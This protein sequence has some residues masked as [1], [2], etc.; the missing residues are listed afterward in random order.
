MTVKSQQNLATATHRT[1][2]AAYKFT[3]KLSGARQ[4]MPTCSSS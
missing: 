1:A 3:T 4:R 2:T